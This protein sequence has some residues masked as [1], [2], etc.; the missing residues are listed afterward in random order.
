[1]NEVSHCLRSSGKNNSPCVSLSETGDLN[2]QETVS[3]FNKIGIGFERDPYTNRLKMVEIEEVSNFSI[4]A[5]N[6]WILP[7]KKG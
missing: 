4:L 1:M 2:P 7:P 5:P 6:T 3:K